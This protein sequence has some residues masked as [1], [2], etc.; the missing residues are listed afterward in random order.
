MSK[1]EDFAKA[2]AENIMQQ[3]SYKLGDVLNEFPAGAHVFVLVVMKR[4]VDTV[5]PLLPE[6]DQKLFKHLVNLTQVAVA[7]SSLDPRKKEEDG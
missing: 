7:P 1:E 3:A 6:M 2:F 5:L 4:M